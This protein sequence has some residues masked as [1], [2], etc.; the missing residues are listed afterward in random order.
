VIIEPEDS[1]AIAPG[2]VGKDG[3]CGGRNGCALCAVHRDPPGRLSLSR[4]RR[5]LIAAAGIAGQRSTGRHA[6]GVE[7]HGSS[8]F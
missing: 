6:S 2:K 1:T 3:L 8:V 5:G 7:A 4:M